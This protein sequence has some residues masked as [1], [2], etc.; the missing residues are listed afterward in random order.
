MTRRA[1][2]LEYRV[3]RVGRKWDRRSGKFTYDISFEARFRETERTTSVLEAFG[4]A[5]RDGRTWVYKRFEFKMS[6]TDVVYITGDSG[7]G[8]SVLLR[9]IESDLGNLSVNVDKV[10]VVWDEPIV[11]TVGETFEEALR[12]LSTVGLNDASLFLR[13]YRE[14]S[15]GQ[16][17]RYRLAKLIESGRQYWIADEFCATLDRDTA[18]VVAYNFQKAARRMGR[19]VIVATTHTDLLEDLGPNVWIRKGW[20]CEVE[21]EYLSGEAPKTCTVSRGVRVKP[22]GVGDYETLSVFHYRSRS[23]P[24]A[25]KVFRM[26]KD[27]RVIGVIV[28]SPPTSMAF[29][30]S[31]AIPGYRVTREWLRWL[32]RNVARI[33]RVI[34]HPKYRSI[35]LGVRL[36]RETLPLVGK[37]YVEAIAVMARYN[38]FFERA[39]MERVAERRPHPAL[40]EVVEEL[41][42]MGLLSAMLRSDEALMGKLR[43]GGPKLVGEVRRLLLERVPEFYHKAIS[44]GRPLRKC[45][46]T[47]DGL[48]RALRRVQ[49]L[50]NT[51]VYLFWRNPKLRPEPFP[52][53]G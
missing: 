24:F 4:Y 17:Y 33:S 10:P 53:G 28:Y 25:P 15:D 16:K 5:A 44:G 14:L 8:K 49:Q 3:R 34:V 46:E 35:G 48:V 7:S 12:L 40:I 32:T 51:T 23:T 22:G 11:D 41:R 47:M 30:R 50:T 18:K 13:T 38:P 21:V 27:G 1:E 45:V 31:K 6:P 9:A 36:V 2:R 26:V 52:G 43:E 29:G 20:G 37:P 19:G 39:G 42:G